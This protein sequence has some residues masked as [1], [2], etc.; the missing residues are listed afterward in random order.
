MQIRPD[1]PFII[2]LNPRS[3]HHDATAT[4]AAIDAVLAPSG[5]AYE[6]RVIDDV[7]QLQETARQAVVDARAR[8]AAVVAAGGD[9]TINTIVQ[10][11]LDHGGDSCAF[12]VLPQGTFN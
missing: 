7:R 4:R 5:R 1:A 9:G 11:V 8:G 10:A 6:V 3:G 12:G 2:L